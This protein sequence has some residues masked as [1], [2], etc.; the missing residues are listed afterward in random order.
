MDRV[1]RGTSATISITFRVD[2]T[3]TD[4]SPDSATV[5]V[6][7]EDGTELVAS[8]AA[9]EAGTG[10]FT[11]ALTPT[12]TA[13]LD[14]LT[15]EW[16][17]TLSAQVQ[18]VRTK[19]E[20]VGEM[21]CSIAEITDALPSGV[22]ASTDEVKAEHVRAESWL[23]DT[24]GVAFRPRYARERLDGSGGVDLLV[25][26]PRPITLVAVTIDDTA[27]TTEERDA[28]EVYESGTLYRASGWASGR[29][30]VEIKYEHGYPIV[31]A[32]V[33]RA[34]IKLA[35]F[36]LTPDPSNRDERATRIETDEASY[37]LVTP[38]VRGAILSIPEVNAVI[39][40]YRYLGVG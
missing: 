29:R 6:V 35:R 22:T 3:P 31:P 5:R 1:I 40:Q 24:C 8:T 21:L 26:N 11:Y 37:S 28:V 7:R 13:Q 12:H 4:P 25:S 33:N 2:G 34:A 20:I 39:E 14:V 19:I 23:E 10:K 30:N 15:A 18:T 9:T 32:P 17:A 38:G 36:F 16:T 27:L